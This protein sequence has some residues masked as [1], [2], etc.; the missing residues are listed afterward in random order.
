MSDD[1]AKALG[2]SEYDMLAAKKQ[3]TLANGKVVEAIGQLELVCSFRTE[4]ESS[5]TMTCVF[6]VLLKV[7][8]P[9]IMGLDFLEQTK[10]MTE[11]RER[12]VRVPRPTYQALSVCSAGKPKRLLACGLNHLVTTATPDT[13]AEVDLMT[14]SSAVVFGFPVHPEE[15]MIELA[16]GSIVTTNGCVLASL[17]VASADK[18]GRP[19]F[20]HS[21]YIIAKFFLLDSLTHD[22][23]V[24]KE[25]L[26]ALGVFEDHQHALISAPDD[27]KF[28]GLNGIRHLGPVD[29]IVSKMKRTFCGASSGTGIDDMQQFHA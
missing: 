14:T 7:A 15:E 22:V 27:S 6:Y 25:S 29:R 20:S 21:N 16:D 13:G 3:F 1:V 28:L 11:H 23:I 8:M 5:V 2:Y 18:L 10:M 19:I 4:I 26:E 24:G 17:W 9:V 12:F